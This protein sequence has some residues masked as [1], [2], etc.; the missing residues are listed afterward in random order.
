M[1]GSDVVFGMQKRTREQPG[2]NYWLHGRRWLAQSPRCATATA[3]KGQTRKSLAACRGGSSVWACGCC[4]A[5][6]GLPPRVAKGAGALTL[7]Q[8]GP[9]RG[10][11]ADQFTSARALMPPRRRLLIRIRVHVP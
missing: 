3:W 4:V 8:V 2:V 10:L 6:Q 5:G 1:D 9:H 11:A 7:V